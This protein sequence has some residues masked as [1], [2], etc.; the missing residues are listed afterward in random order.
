MTN[1]LLLNWNS[2]KDIESCLNRF[3]NEEIDNLRIIV[4]DNHSD[5][6]DRHYLQK[7]VQQYTTAHPHFNIHLIENSYNDGYSGG[8]NFGYR[9]LENNDLHGDVLILNPDIYITA[10]T[11]NVMQE[12]L[13]KN[14]D[15]GGVMVR[16]LKTD[17]TVL[18]DH[19]KMRGLEQDWL[20]CEEDVCETD[21]LAGSCMLLRR[22]VLKKTGLFNA[23]FFM[24]WE[25]TDLSFRIKEAGYRLLSTTL[26]SITR[27]DNEIGRGLNMH[28]Y[29][30]R[31]AIL[32]YRLHTNISLLDI[33][34]Y[35]IKMIR[36][37]VFLTLK[38]RTGSYLLKYLQGIKNGI[39]IDPRGSGKR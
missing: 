17:G 31:N 19:I 15:A 35:L 30:V 3:V 29:M 23:A 7:V 14:E 11:I 25:E 38:H 18:Y 21:Y 39:A 10:K 9:Y 27:R 12:V 5:D 8:N 20:K 4:I 2:S 28:Y 24:Y 34:G 1:I 32:M 37:T 26:G 6:S 16:T 33:L 22:D 36:T 13:Q